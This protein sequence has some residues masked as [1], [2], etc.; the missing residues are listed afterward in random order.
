[1]T[2]IELIKKYAHGDDELIE[3]FT[4][5][6]DCDD[7]PQQKECIVKYNRQRIKLIKTYAQEVYC[8]VCPLKKECT[9]KHESMG[10]C[11]NYLMKVLEV[12]E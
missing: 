12:E 4:Q 11:I 6:V 1:M 9:V 7:C 2:I 10:N 3:T 5:E 8:D